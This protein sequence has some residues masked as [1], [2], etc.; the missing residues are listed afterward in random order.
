VLGHRHRFDC[1]ANFLCK[2][3]CL[4]VLWALQNLCWLW[5]ALPTTHDPNAIKV[6]GPTIFW[7]GLFRLA[8]L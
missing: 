1:Y 8:V 6:D 3:N 4:G 2:T 5:S 7:W